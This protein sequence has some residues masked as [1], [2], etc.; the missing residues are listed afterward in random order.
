VLFGCEH[1][2]ALAYEI[3]GARLLRLDRVGHELP[4]AVWDDAVHAILRQS[5]AI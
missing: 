1:G 4:W 5:E 3:P 2:M